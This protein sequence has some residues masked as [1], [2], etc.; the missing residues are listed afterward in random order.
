[1]LSEGLELTDGVPYARGGFA[2]IWRGTY[3]GSQVAVK[4][5]RVSES[6]NTVK[7]VSC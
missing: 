4:V 6:D 3:N 5:L 2:D 7:K 1:M